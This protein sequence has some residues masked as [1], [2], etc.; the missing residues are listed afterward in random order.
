MAV[1]CAVL[2]SLVQIEQVRP[3]STALTSRDHLGLVRPFEQ[4]RAPGRRFPRVRCASSA[5]LGEHGRLDVEALGERRVGGPLAAADQPRAFCS[6]GFD[7]SSCT[8]SYCALRDDRA[9]GGG[10]IGRDARL[11]MRDLRLDALDHRV[12]DLLVDEGAAGRAAGLAAPGEV[13]AADHA[14]P[15]PRRDRHRDRRSARSCRRVRASPASPC[16]RPRASPRVRSAPMPISATLATPG[17]DASTVRRPRV[18]PGTTLNTPGGSRPSSNSASRSD[19]SGAC[20]G[21]LTTTVLPAASGAADLPAQ[22]MNG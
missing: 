14:A 16:R 8:R 22:N 21:G 9:H 1:R 12:V 7:D 15:R 18:P 19:E 3:Y 5:S 13:H 2:R 10:R 11:E 20:S 17:C 6:S 4:T